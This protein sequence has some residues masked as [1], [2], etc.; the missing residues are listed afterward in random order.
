MKVAALIFALWCAQVLF[1][2]GVCNA[3]FQ[4][5]YHAGRE[6]LGECMAIS[7]NPTAFIFMPMMS[8]FMES[9]W[10]LR[11]SLEAVP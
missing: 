7:L 2:T 6:G 10:S 4:S 8:G 11:T 9:G 1:S 3:Y 5:Q